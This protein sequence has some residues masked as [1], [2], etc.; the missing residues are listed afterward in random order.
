MLNRRW[1]NAVGTVFLCSA[2]APNL[3]SADMQRA[4][5][6]MVKNTGKPVI[7]GE[8]GIRGSGY[9]RAT[10]G[11]TR[12]ANPPLSECWSRSESRQA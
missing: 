10:V 3:Q 6:E 11:G 9:D 12:P 5:I 7:L 1:N 2:C 8:F 4:V